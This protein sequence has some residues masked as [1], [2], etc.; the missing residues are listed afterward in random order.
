MN[1]S[2]QTLLLVLTTFASA[3]LREYTLP[4]AGVSADDSASPFSVPSMQNA[5]LRKSKN[6]L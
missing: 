6:S 5:A 3:T 1:A 2:L 4:L